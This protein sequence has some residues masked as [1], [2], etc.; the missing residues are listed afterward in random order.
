MT[1]KLAIVIVTYNRSS[2]LEALLR[3]ITYSTVLP[4]IIVVI[5]NC[6]TDETSAVIEAMSNKF[7][8][9]EFVN[10]KMSSNTGGAGGFNEGI[11]I[12][13]GLGASWF[14]LMD[15]DVELL[16]E[17]IARLSKWTNK[18]KCIHGRRVD[19][20]GSDFFW[21][22]IFNEWL[23]LPLPY[24]KNPFSNNNYFIT[25]TGCFEGMLIHADIVKKIGLP[26]SRFFITWDDAIYGWLASKVTEVVYVN[27]FVLKRSRRQ[28]QLNIG[29]RHL[30]DASDLFRFHVVRNREFVR[31]YLVHKNCY[32]PI[33]FLIGSILN[34]SKEIFRLIFVEHSLVGVNAL[35][36][37][38]KEGRKIKFLEWH[39]MPEIK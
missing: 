34:F 31:K 8:N 20:D 33:G 26:D 5:D 15:D 13:M 27:D 36:H 14:W 22:P 25:N 18:F 3:S 23:G 17:G 10:H 21:Q 16:P 39:A 9:L 35:L 30:N 1:E 6:S 29:V 19:F 32:S 24:L 4:E 12:A 7:S 38:W 28:K 37:G 11:N 2:L